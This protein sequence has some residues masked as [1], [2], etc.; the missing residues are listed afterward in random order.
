[1]TGD[2]RWQSGVKK[3]RDGE[4]KECAFKGGKGC[5]GYRVCLF[6]NVNLI[7]CLCA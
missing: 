4:L 1:M 2:P 7:M 5:N 6:H 3:L